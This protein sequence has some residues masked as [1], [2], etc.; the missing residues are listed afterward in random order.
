[1][2]AHSGMHA[3]LLFLVVPV[4]FAITHAASSSCEQV[5]GSTPDHR[6]AAVASALLQTKS[7]VSSVKHHDYVG[8]QKNERGNLFDNTMEM[9]KFIWS[10][11]RPEEWKCD[12]IPIGD[13]REK[14]CNLGRESLKPELLDCKNGCGVEQANS[15]RTMS[16][17]GALPC[18][19]T[20]PFCAAPACTKE[21]PAAPSTCT[22][23]PPHEN[24]AYMQLQETWP[25]YHG[26]GGAFELDTLKYLDLLACHGE[27]CP[28]KTFDL[29]IDLGANTGY[30][31]E[32][33]AVRRFAKDYLMVEANPKTTQVLQDYRFGN[34]DFKQ[35]WFTQ[36][37]GQKEG[38]PLPEFEIICQALSSHADGFL[39]M[40][41]TEGSMAA[42]ECNVKIASVDSLLAESLTSSFKN[43]VAEA[44]SAFIKID[45]EGMD[46]LVLRGMQGLLQEQRGTHADGSPRHLVNFMQFE[47]SPALMKKAQDRESFQNYDLKTTTQFLESIGFETF[48]IGPRFLPL[49][50][51]SWDDL[52]KT[53]TQDPANNAGALTNYP[54]FDSRLC[55]WCPTMVNE[56]SFT[57]DV[58]AMRA[59]HP[60]AA[61]IKVALGACQESK[62]F[63]PNDPQ[64]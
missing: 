53:W 46:E 63:D 52:Y 10:M 7:G 37:V 24:V 57:T 47:Y 43:K 1:M 5:E 3:C 62:D 58:F 19:R 12:M 31:T 16:W 51:G 56:P 20:A 35:A 13:E 61:E 39:D 9:E 49:S 34:A 28:D 32:K 30:F 64:Y 15:Y 54:T 4:A 59:S 8:R 23:R 38:E 45:T 33:V 17:I 60:R 18:C 48:L 27:D 36:Q 21:Q 41:Q 22:K 29:M 26:H 11:T 14:T 55:T 42:S 40:C 25:G 44:Q 50:H 6:C 2:A